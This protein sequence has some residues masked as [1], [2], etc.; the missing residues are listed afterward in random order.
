M[1]LGW[2]LL[3]TYGINCLPLIWTPRSTDFELSKTAQFFIKDLSAA[4][5]DEDYCKAECRDDESCTGYFYTQDNTYCIEKSTCKGLCGYFSK[6]YIPLEAGNYSNGIP[7]NAVVSMK[8]NGLSALVK[9][10]AT[11][12]DECIST[13]L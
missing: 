4:N 8:L 9:R 13:L 3:L 10:A 5:N 1:Q 6:A 7:L 2:I 12:F 11:E